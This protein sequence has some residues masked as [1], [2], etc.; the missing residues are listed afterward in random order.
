MP[1]FFLKPVIFCFTKKGTAY[2]RG[3]CAKKKKDV[4]G[5][6]NHSSHRYLLNTHY[7]PITIQIKLG[8]Q[9]VFKYI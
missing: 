1:K 9:G 4:K 5:K 2:S 7:V 8:F 3:I 6:I